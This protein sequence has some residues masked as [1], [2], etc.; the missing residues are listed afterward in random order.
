MHQ[1]KRRLANAEETQKQIPISSLHDSGSTH[2]SEERCGDEIAAWEFIGCPARR[3]SR[4]RDAVRTRSRDTCASWFIGRILLTWVFGAASA[5]TQP[6]SLTARLTASPLAQSSF[7]LDAGG[8][9]YGW[10][11]NQHGKLGL[12]TRSTNLHSSEPTPMRVPFPPGVTRWTTVAGGTWHTLAIGDDGRVYAAGANTY[13]QLGTETPG[14]RLSFGLVPLPDDPHK[15]V[16]LAAG[17]HS[18]ALR[19]DG[20]LY[21]WGANYNGQLGNG[22]QINQSVRQL[23]S[24][25]IGVSKW[26]SIA[27]GE[28][29]SLAIADNGT[30]YA[31]GQGYYGQLGSGSNVMQLSP[32]AVAFPDGVTSWLSVSASYKST[33]ALGNNGSIYGWGANSEGELGNGTTQMTN[34]PVRVATPVGISWRKLMAGGNEGFALT[35]DGT[36]Y[37]WGQNYWGE[38]G[39]GFR[40]RQTV[41]ALVPFPG[42][43][44]N[45][46]ADIAGGGAHALGLGSDCR[47]YQWG[48][49]FSALVPEPTPTLLADLAN[50]CDVASNAPPAV[51][52][53]SPA[54]G[55][56]VSVPGIVLLQA[57]AS[58]ADGSISEV[59]FFEGDT[60]LGSGTVSTGV[61]ALIWTIGTPGHPVITA[62]AID[63][64]GLSSISQPVTITAINSNLPTVNLFILDG[65][66]SE[67]GPHNAFFGIARTGNTNTFLPVNIALGGSAVP[68]VD[69]VGLNYTYLSNFVVIPARA[70]G[71]D[72]GIHPLADSVLEGEETVV[73]TLLD[74][75][76]YNAG[77]SNRIVLTIAD[78]AN[79]HSNEAPYLRLI[80]PAANSASVSPAAIPLK[81]VIQGALLPDATVEFLRGT[82]VVGASTNVS[83]NPAT[84]LFVFSW[85]NA[86]P[87]RHT[88]YAQTLDTNGVIVSSQPV[89]ITVLA[90]TNLPQVNLGGNT[91]TNRNEIVVIGQPNGVYR[92]ESSTNLVNWTALTTSFSTKGVIRFV[93][94]QAG[95]SA[96]RFYRA[97]VI[98]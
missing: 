9:L 83:S 50:L 48:L 2:R 27:A 30:L 72:L 59:K 96:Q 63:D 3:V 12:G 86:P 70:S 53:I 24:L 19:D 93:D 1:M 90:S 8:T 29:H 71:V 35:T 43:L 32:V 51:A 4:R 62:R 88:L 49:R 7:V 23:V 38:C 37:A 68:G 11:D 5:W 84:N 10:E 61:Y 54:D 44:S 33:F 22:N 56:T 55:T 45:G 73:F 66:A 15:W 39:L 20:Q 87:G 77:L 65:A 42:G 41:P 28:A 6:A 80:A 25:P 91:A 16:A 74:G 52:V 98:P 58:D 60:L 75:A 97:V 64:R 57:N 46:W 47:L 82:T 81:A 76:N 92:I 34:V 79:A 18:L 31:W 40:G 26:S 14:D 36:L 17:D 69:Y 89:P 85:T 67:A 95:A 78:D 21:A 94:P 13:K